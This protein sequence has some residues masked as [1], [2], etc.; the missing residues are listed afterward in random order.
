[1]ASFSRLAQGETVIAKA[2]ENE[3]EGRGYG[4]FRVTS[5][6]SGSTYTVRG[7]QDNGVERW[8]CNCRWSEFG[9]RGCSHARA[10]RDLI[11][12]ER[13]ELVACS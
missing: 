8:T 11:R 10:A 2:D 12:G 5:A 13:I 1:M 7:A 6:S 4:W 9:G 3:V